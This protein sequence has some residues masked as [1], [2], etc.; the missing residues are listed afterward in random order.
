M[1]TEGR[2][3]Q[4][5]KK[6]LSRVTGLLVRWN[7]LH[8]PYG[9]EYVREHYSWTGRFDGGSTPSP[10]ASEQRLS[11]PTEGGDDLSGEVSRPSRPDGGQPPILTNCTEFQRHCLRAISAIESLSS[12]ASADAVKAWL[13]DSTR[14]DSDEVGYDRIST[15][16]DTLVNAGY[17]EA[18]AAESLRRTN[19]YRTT[20]TGDQALARLDATAESEE[21]TMEPDRDVAPTDD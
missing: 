17:A 15:A 10:A 20:A 4:L 18:G 7:L 3:V 11:A 5:R 13:E 6:L 1:Y 19:T 21:G 8:H 9:R 2:H 16:L 14:C 12:A